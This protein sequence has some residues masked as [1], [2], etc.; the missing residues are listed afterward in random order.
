LIPKLITPGKNLGYKDIYLDFLAGKN[1]PKRF[2][3]ADCFEGVTAKLD[4]RNYERDKLAAILH[5]QNER[6]GASNETLANIER[7]CDPRAVCVLAGQQ[8]GL[9][10][11]PLFSVIKMLSVIK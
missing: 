3:L 7:L 9:M 1:P 10:G 4:R 6:Y 2:Y 5:R 8:A 11:G